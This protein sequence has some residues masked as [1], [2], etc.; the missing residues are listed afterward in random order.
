MTHVS[1]AHSQLPVTE[2]AFRVAVLLPCYNE[3][4]AIADVIKDF[5]DVLPAA[6]IYVY[7][8]NS[9]DQTA[10]IARNSGAIVRSERNQGKG[11]VLRRMFADI[12]ADIYVLADGDGTYDAASAPRLIHRLIEDQLDFVNGSRVSQ[13]ELAY[14]PGHRFG[15]VLL[16]GLV[17]LFFGRQFQDIL[18]GYKILTRRFAKSFPAVSRGFETETELAVHALELR[19]PCAEVET[20]YRERPPNSVSKLRTFRDGFRILTMIA[21]LVKMERP[22][23][24]FGLLGLALVLIGTGLGLPVVLE[25]LETGL[26]P[27]LPTTLLSIGLMLTG[28][29]SF[30]SGLILDMLTQ[31]RR[32]IKRLIYL[33]IPALSAR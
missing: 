31:T 20:V 22:L 21:L 27:R 11:N 13:A 17:Q 8:N 10:E 28:V 5:R 18:S 1:V 33:G 15:N 16:T 25:Y 9:T 26:V 24:F 3:A 30:F 32:E 12:D 6:D 2:Y 4:V 7:D 14:R 29:I 23:Q 19:M